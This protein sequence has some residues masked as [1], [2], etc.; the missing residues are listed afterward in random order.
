M[1]DFF[2]EMAF[3][4]IATLF[5]S[6]IEGVFILP[7]HVAHSKA[8]KKDNKPN[9][10]MKATSGSME[11]MRDKLYKPFLLYSL[12]NRSFALAVPFAL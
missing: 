12:R 4:V 11:W 3:I 10:F 5:F 8:L 7:A 2:K 6:L 1:G 9:K